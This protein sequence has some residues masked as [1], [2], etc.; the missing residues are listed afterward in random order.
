VRQ[1]APSIAFALG[2]IVLIAAFIALVRAPGARSA[3]FYAEL[4]ALEIAAIALA[5]V[6]QHLP[7]GRDHRSR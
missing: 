4:V 5:L 3:L 2:T 7:A 6:T 1:Y